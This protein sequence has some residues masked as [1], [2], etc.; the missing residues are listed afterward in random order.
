MCCL[1]LKINTSVGIVQV[2]LYFSLVFFNNFI[3]NIISPHRMHNI[4]AA[5]CYRRC[6]VVCQSVYWLRLGVP[7]KTITKMVTQGH[8]QFHCFTERIIR[9]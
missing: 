7:Q 9:Y 8:R 6:D 5:Y 1:E 2:F 3:R 4:H